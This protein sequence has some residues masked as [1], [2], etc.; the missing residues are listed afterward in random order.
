[1]VL[2]LGLAVRDESISA[3]AQATTGMGSRTSRG[4]ALNELKAREMPMAQIHLVTEQETASLGRS[5]RGPGKGHEG[6]HRWN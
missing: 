4:P 5:H 6:H 3:F 2:V 1:M